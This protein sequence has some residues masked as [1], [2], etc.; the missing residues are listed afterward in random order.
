MKYFIDT[1]FLEGKQSKRLLGVKY[2][3]TKPTIDLISIGIVGE[4]GSEYYA[5]SKDFNLKEA[6]NRC[7]LIKSKDNDGYEYWIRY[8]I[9]KPIFNDLIMWNGDNDKYSQFTY[10]NFKYLLNKYGLSNKKIAKEIKSFI[11]YNEEPDLSS[12]ELFHPEFKFSDISFYG[13]FSDYDWVVFC[14]LFGRMVDLPKGFPMYCIDLKQEL[15]NKVNKITNEELDSIC[16]AGLMN[17]PKEMYRYPLDLKYKLNHIKRYH[18][19]YPKQ[20]NEHNALNDARWNL[21]LYKF[22]QII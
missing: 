14:Q 2:G 7:D 18:N 8:N 20:T 4:D 16:N 11:A 15:D 3:E 12:I 5:I 6:W 10:K 1:E 21:E 17:H 22:L 19:N 13:Y 9:L